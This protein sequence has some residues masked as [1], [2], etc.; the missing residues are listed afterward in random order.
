VANEARVTLFHEFEGI[1]SVHWVRSSSS[2]TAESAVLI[3]GGRKGHRL[4][5]GKD[6]E[7]VLEVS[8]ELREEGINE[9]TE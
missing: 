7:R 5:C 6:P 1:R 4:P 2:A 8:V 9:I 3:G